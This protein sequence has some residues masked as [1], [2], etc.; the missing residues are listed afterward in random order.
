[1]TPLALGCGLTA[2]EEGPVVAAACKRERRR[3]NIKGKRRS[4]KQIERRV[5][6]FGRYDLYI[7]EDRRVCRV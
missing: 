3:Y 1:M 2:T 7:N 5:G 4:N 6:K